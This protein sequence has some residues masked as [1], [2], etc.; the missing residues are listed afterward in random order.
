MFETTTQDYI[1]TILGL[2]GEIGITCTVQTDFREFLDLCRFL[3]GKAR[4]ISLFDPNLT[5]VDDGNAF[6]IK[7][8]DANGQVVH[9]Q[10]VRNLNTGD[11]SL[12]RHFERNARLYM[13]QDCDIDLARSE[14]H[15]APCTASIHGNICYHGEI[16]LHKRLRGKALTLLLPR[17]AIAMAHQKWDPDYILGFT[18]PK[19]SYKGIAV[20]Y[21][22]MH[23]QAGAINWYVPANDSYEID[24]LVWL[25]REEMEYLTAFPVEE[26]RAYFMPRRAVSTVQPQALSAS[27]G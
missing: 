5:D 7:G 24:W 18:H 6:W 21:G 3:D 9:V 23:C 19:H 12:A 2:A 22:Y 4:P 17:L 20:Q 8:T 15:S 26:E 1:D 25:S 10:A 11:S 27:G 16:W 14:F 13:I